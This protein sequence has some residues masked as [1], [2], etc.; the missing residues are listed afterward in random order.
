M[1][2]ALSS[3][4]LRALAAEWQDL[5]GAHIDKVYQRGDEVIIR[6][7]VPDRGKAE[8]FSKSGRWLCIHEIENKPDSPPPFAQ[9]LRRLLGNAIVRAVEQRGFDRIAVFRLE[10]GA[11]A[12]DAVFEVFGKGN[13]MVVKDGTT[14]V[15]LFPQTFKDRAVEIGEPYAFPAA[16]VDPL[17][18]DRS[19]FAN[20]LR[21]AKGQLVRVLASVLNLGGAYAEEICLRGNVDK[22][23]KV[24]ELSD[25][26]VDALYT[27]LNNVAVAV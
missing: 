23:T 4:D 1:K 12:F 14:V 24:K 3:F 20:T 8:L 21:G 7:N 22:E 13:L 9:T 27:A 11:D 16:G 18:L 10:R 5:V 2:T 26:Q 19:G 15:A 6:I 25:A 17:E